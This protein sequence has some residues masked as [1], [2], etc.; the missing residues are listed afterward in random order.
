[1]NGLALCVLYIG[2]VRAI[3]GTDTLL[4]I[5]SVAIGAFIGELI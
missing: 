1:M 3:K 5:I 2:I 4:T